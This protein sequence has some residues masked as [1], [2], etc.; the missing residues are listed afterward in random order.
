[1]QVLNRAVYVIRHLPKM[2]RMRL[3]YW[4][5]TL[6]SHWLRMKTAK[7]SIYSSCVALTVLTRRDGGHQVHESFNTLPNHG[8]QARV[9]STNL[10]QPSENSAAN[11]RSA[12]QPIR[13]APSNANGPRLVFRRDVAGRGRRAV[14]VH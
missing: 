5:K 11:H 4:L 10:E 12:G 13:F 7:H 3:F 6:H 9:D 14:S 8:A 1:M 2:L